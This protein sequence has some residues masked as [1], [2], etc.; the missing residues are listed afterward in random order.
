MG[1]ITSHSCLI[2]N[3][4]LIKSSTNVIKGVTGE[5]NSW[6]DFYEP[7]SRWADVHP[8]ASQS[9]RQIWTRATAHPSDDIINTGQ[10][11]HTRSAGADS[12]WGA[13]LRFV[14]WRLQLCC[15]Q[16]RSAR[17]SSI[18][19]LLKMCTIKRKV[20]KCKFIVNTRRNTAGLR[21]T[22]KY[23]RIEPH[24]QNKSEVIAVHRVLP[25]YVFENYILVCDLFLKQLRLYDVI[26][27]INCTEFG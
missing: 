11:P 6:V 4:G 27:N 5:T 17:L 2:I 7:C 16:G 13:L 10:I 22:V 15:L 21:D 26:N 18:Y 23:G 24:L 19:T 14:L 3:L 20:G 25:S 12:V 9:P 1:S 8:A